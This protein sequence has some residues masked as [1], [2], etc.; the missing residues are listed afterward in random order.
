MFLVNFSSQNDP[1][2]NISRKSARWGAVFP[3]RLNVYTLSKYQMSSQQDNPLKSASRS[4]FARRGNRGAKR[5]HAVV[6]HYPASVFVDSASSSSGDLQHLGSTRRTI[7]TPNLHASG[8]NVK[9]NDE[10]EIWTNHQDDQ[11]KMA[12]TTKPKDLSLQQSSSFVVTNAELPIVDISAFD[13]DAYRHKLIEAALRKRY[14]DYQPPGDVVLNSIHLNTNDSTVAVRLNDRYHHSFF[15]FVEEYYDATKGMSK[16]ETEYL[17]PLDHFL[18]KGTQK[19]ETVERETETRAMSLAEDSVGQDEKS[20]RISF[21]DETVVANS[22]AQKRQRSGDLGTW[23]MLL[24]VTVEIVATI[25]VRVLVHRL[26][27]WIRVRVTLLSKDGGPCNV[28]A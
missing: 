9:K 22:S 10:L 12:V 20:P 15:D 27:R 21:F 8:D 2:F 14:D 16:K 13:Y 25:L 3:S 5:S 24:S 6:M 7:S 28:I 17:H 23:R 18:V 4:Y 26:P 1:T 19:P 11:D